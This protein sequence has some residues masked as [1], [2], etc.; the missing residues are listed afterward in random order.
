MGR[1]KK[2]Q[3]RV[4]KPCIPWTKLEDEKLLEAIQVYGLSRWKEVAD[5]VGTK[6]ANS[7]YQHWTRVLDPSI[8]K[9]KFSEKELLH[10]AWVVAKYGEHRWKSVAND[11]VGRT[12]TQCR[13]RWGEISKQKTK[14]YQ[15]VWE[16]YQKW[17]TE[18]ETLGIDRCVEPDC[19]ISET[20][21]H[22]FVVSM[23]TTETGEALSERPVPFNPAAKSAERSED[24]DEEV[25]KG[26]RRKPARRE[27]NERKKV[28]AY[29]Q[30]RHQEMPSS[31]ETQREAL[32]SES[33]FWNARGTSEDKDE[34][35]RKGHRRKPARREVNERKKVSAYRQERHQEMPSSS[36]TQREA[37]DSESDF[38]N[39]RDTATKSDFG[40]KSPGKEENARNG[41][42][43]RAWDKTP[44]TDSSMHVISL[45]EKAHE[46]IL[47][48]PRD[49]SASVL[50]HGISKAPAC[51]IDTK[52]GELHTASGH[53]IISAHRESP[54][55]L[56]QWTPDSAH[57]NSPMLPLGLHLTFT[58]PVDSDSHFQMFE[59]RRGEERSFLMHDQGESHSRK[60]NR[61]CLILNEDDVMEKRCGTEL[62]HLNVI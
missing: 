27:V 47:F 53:R 24:K 51:I 58:D 14:F 46:K 17:T 32:D 60:M 34:E 56:M 3:K 37:L 59:R 44:R 6:S 40:S 21:F 7:C 36:E 57:A 5:V 41:D 4:R 26:H 38:W 1:R 13:A 35:V 9:K 43:D 39:A 15:Y 50:E 61:I 30:E 25:R 18:I 16:K 10:L 62:M 49:P 45:G 29:R 20:E 31:S 2:F 12:D 52:T 55:S 23:D 48:F 8:S 19:E 33:D 28:S 42:T 11:M 22:E 54:A